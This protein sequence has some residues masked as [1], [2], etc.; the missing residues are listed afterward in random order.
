MKKA[1]IAILLVVLFIMGILGCSQFIISQSKEPQ[2]ASVTIEPT[3][4]EVPQT[5]ELSQDKPEATPEKAGNI[6]TDSGRYS[7]QADS[8][9]IEIKISGVPDENAAKLFMLSED[10]KNNFNDLKLETGDD[11]KFDYYVNEKEQNVIV[12]IEKK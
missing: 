3:D 5:P 2:K 12:S 8:N 10:L 1:I 9:F 7:G 4:N 6:K 11:V